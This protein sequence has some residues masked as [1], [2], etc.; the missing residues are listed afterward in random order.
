MAI[1]L[2]SAISAKKE[3]KRGNRWILKFDAIPRT[4]GT[5]SIDGASDSA[6]ATSPEEVLAIDLVSAARPTLSFNS[7]EVSRLNE[8]WK[9]A[10]NPTWDPITV[11]FYDY[12][13]G[14]HSATQILWA[15]SQTVYDVLNGTMGYAASYKVDASLIMLGPGQ[16][17]QQAGTASKTNIDIIEAWDLFGCFPNNLTTGTLTYESTDIMQVSVEI[18][19]DYANLHS[20]SD[21]GV[22]D[23]VNNL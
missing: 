6:D 14:A 16:S 1:S 10:S 7:T 20:T 22:V 19:F 8:K 15:W 17:V 23:W 18:Q 12:D 13:R 11:A 2:S 4:G 3:P 21:V 9:F 5:N